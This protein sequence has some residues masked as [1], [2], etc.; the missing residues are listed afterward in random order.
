VAKKPKRERAIRREA[1]RRSASIAKDAERLFELE[2]GGSAERPIE[3][4]SPSIVE[5]RSRA[6]PCPRCGGPHR[7]EEHAAVAVAGVRLREARLTCRSCGSRRSM[8][9]QLPLYN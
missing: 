1:Q 6:T 7:V 8:W 9:F 2:P 5:S 3:V 4:D